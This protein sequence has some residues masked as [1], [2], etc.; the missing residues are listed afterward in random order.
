MKYEL[1]EVRNMMYEEVALM[2]GDDVLLNGDE[3]HNDIFARIEG[4][5]KGLEYCGN[6]VVVKVVKIDNKTNLSLFDKLEFYDGE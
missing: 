4:F 1:T 2:N 3:C 5:I 6:T